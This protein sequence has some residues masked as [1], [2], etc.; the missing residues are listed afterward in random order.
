VRFRR[1]CRRGALG[2]SELAVGPRR[3]LM[4]RQR[5]ARGTASASVMPGHMVDRRTSP[6]NESNLGGV[7]A[8][9]ADKHRKLAVGE[10]IRSH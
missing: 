1:K 5:R 7:P 8:E 3:M 6:N 4:A 2:A 10:T 9:L